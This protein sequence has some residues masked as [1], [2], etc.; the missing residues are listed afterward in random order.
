[1][2]V[3]EVGGM[4]REGSELEITSTSWS[5]RWRWSKDSGFWWRDNNL[6]GEMM[7]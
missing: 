7:V 3:V 4:D 1:V 6:G 2:T 5:G